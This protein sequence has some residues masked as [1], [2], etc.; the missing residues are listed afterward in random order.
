MILN[1]MRIISPPLFSFFAKPIRPIRFSRQSFKTIPLKHPLLLLYKLRCCI[2]VFSCSS[3]RP[4]TCTF[5]SKVFDLLFAWL[6][7]WLTAIFVIFQ[8]S[9][10]FSWA[11]SNI[12][13][14]RCA[15]FNLGLKPTADISSW[16]SSYE[17]VFLIFSIC[18]A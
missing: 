16:L 12:S 15:P 4:S 11:L 10:G 14:C 3:L 6:L 13:R 8:F 7:D 5:Q 9:A 18:C 2:C 17:H 1:R